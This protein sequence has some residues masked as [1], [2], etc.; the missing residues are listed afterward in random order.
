MIK[1]S[2]RHASALLFHLKRAAV[3]A[4]AWS[5]DAPPFKR[6]LLRAFTSAPLYLVTGLALLCLAAFAPPPPLPSCR[7]EQKERPFQ[8]PFQ[9]YPLLTALWT[10]DKGGEYS[11]AAHPCMP[12]ACAMIFTAGRFNYCRN[13]QLVLP[14]LL[15]IYLKSRVCWNR[16]AKGQ[17]RVP[18]LGLMLL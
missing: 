9:M 10:R 12:I 1:P 3:R 14:P 2:S 17:A 4:D 15:H 18:H 6:A 16:T 11:S 13:I 7:G 8:R 5:A